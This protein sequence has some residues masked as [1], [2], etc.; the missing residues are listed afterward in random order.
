VNGD[1]KGPAFEQHARAYYEGKIT[2]NEFARETM[3][4]WRSLA[5]YLLRRWRAPVWVEPEDVVQDLLE[6]AWRR[7]WDYDEARGVGIAG[8]LIYNA[9]DYAKK[10]LHKTR[11]AKRSGNADGNPSRL[12]RS[13]G[14]VWGDDGERRAEALTALEAEQDRALSRTDMLRRLHGAAEGEAERWLLSVAEGQCLLSDALAGD[15]AALVEVAV[16]V[17]GDPEGRRRLGLRDE[18]HAV[19]VVFTA[20]AA[21]AGKAPKVLREEDA[22]WLPAVR[23]GVTAA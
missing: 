13:Y 20:A 23:V 7:L 16:A 15:P 18:K 21:L 12:E 8:Y 3:P 4:Q 17:Y 22:W 19:R 14:A 2:F 9:T 5:H 6:G 1:S 11:N 10:K